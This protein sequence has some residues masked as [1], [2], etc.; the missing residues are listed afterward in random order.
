MTGVGEACEAS[1]SGFDDD[2]GWALGARFIELRR[3]PE[4]REPAAARSIGYLRPPPACMSWVKRT[5]S[6]F[7][8]GQGKRRPIPR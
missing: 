1:G 7:I 8:V 3:R 2:Q 6:L 4:R 5:P